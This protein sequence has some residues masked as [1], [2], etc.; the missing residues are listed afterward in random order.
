MAKFMKKPIVVDAIQWIGGK[1]DCLNEFLGHEWARADAHDMYYQDT[2]QVIVFNKEE[3]QWL[4]CPVGHW[5]IRGIKGEYYPCS[6]D[7]FE[8]TY[9]PVSAEKP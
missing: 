7:V 9:E 4:H 6:P 8:K 1:F 5:I 2:E 3:D